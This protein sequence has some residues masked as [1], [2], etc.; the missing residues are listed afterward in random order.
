M[1]YILHG[2]KASNVEGNELA[3]RLIPF[4]SLSS[5]I[6]PTCCRQENTTATLAPKKQVTGAVRARNAARQAILREKT[7]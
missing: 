4:T 7:R 2:M 5:C 3:I 1:A 6:C